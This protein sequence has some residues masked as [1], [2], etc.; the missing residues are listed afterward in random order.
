LR[1]VQYKLAADIF[2]GIK[3]GQF[4][5]PNLNLIPTN[6]VD[7]FNYFLLIG[8][9]SQNL[10]NQ[11]DEVIDAYKNSLYWYHLS[12]ESFKDNGLSEIKVD[13]GEFKETT[14]I[15]SNFAEI[16]GSIFK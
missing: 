14:K 1:A 12:E 4:E 2:K 15:I 5:N 9:I 13:I 16:N 10:E 8:R 11:I 7:R 6:T 3:N